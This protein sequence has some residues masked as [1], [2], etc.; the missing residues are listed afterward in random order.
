MNFP[1]ARFPV[2]FLLLKRNNEGVR[3]KQR[4]LS[5]QLWTFK[6][7]N[8]P[9][10]GRV[11]VVTS[12]HLEG[13]ETATQLGRRGC[14]FLPN[15]KF[16]FWMGGCTESSTLISRSRRPERSP[17]LYTKGTLL[18]TKGTEL[19]RGSPAEESDHLCANEEFCL[20][21]LQLWPRTLEGDP[22]SLRL[23]WR[24]AKGRFWSLLPMESRF[25]GRT[26][27]PSESGPGNSRSS[28]NSR[29]LRGCLLRGSILLPHTEHC[30][31]KEVPPLL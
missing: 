6:C 4:C 31:R 15:R 30:C 8:P 17:T 29:N 16:I 19:A 18:Y 26:P 2:L 13:G 11:G 5:F 14:D 23:N 7:W 3:D 21:D 12:H 25:L 20:P 28:T 24:S 1:A 27:Q 22:R 9:G 10:V